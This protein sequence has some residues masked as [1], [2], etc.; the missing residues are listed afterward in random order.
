[1]QVC[2]PF[3]GSEGYG[4]VNGLPTVVVTLITWVGAS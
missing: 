4:H 3:S 2:A 1:M